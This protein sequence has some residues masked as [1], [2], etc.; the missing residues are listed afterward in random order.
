MHKLPNA[1][2]MMLPWSLQ[3][4]TQKQKRTRLRP[5]QKL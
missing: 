5:L 2:K 1:L 4:L 3:T